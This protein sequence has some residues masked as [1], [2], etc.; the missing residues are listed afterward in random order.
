MEEAAVW[1]A[2]AAAGPVEECG[3]PV[4]HIGDAA[5]GAG[6]DLALTG[7]PHAGGRARIFVLRRSL[8][9]DLLA[10]AGSLQDRG[11]RLVVEDGFRTVAMQRALAQLPEVIGAVYERTR[12]EVGGEPPR[13]LL[14][15]RLGVMVAAMPV[16]GTHMSA[17]AVDVSVVDRATG[18]ELDR[19]GPYLEIS[20]RTPMDSPFVTA[21]QREV[22]ELV[23]SC[24]AERG[25]MPFPFEFWH[26][27][28]GDLIDRHVRA[29]P[30]P[31][32]YG[33]VDV[34][35]G[36]GAVTPLADPF[37]RLSDPADLD[38]LFARARS[39][40]RA[41]VSGTV[42][43]TDSGTDPGTVPESVPE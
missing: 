25:F 42:P 2:A 30:A 17:T 41:P 23:T 15:R 3:E 32:R 4:A 34:D 19:G 31:A 6:V 35:L 11:V 29:D 37:Q 38:R 33:P 28:K 20:E 21:E 18:A 5:R 40:I 16:V 7:R 1:S 13:A 43:G 22:R 8:V 27:S 24:M 9:D 39:D 14:E 12:W 36:T 10:V 26:Y